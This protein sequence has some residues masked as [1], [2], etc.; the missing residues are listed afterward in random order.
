[1]T[2]AKH[3]LLDELIASGIERRE[4]RWIIEE[5]ALDDSPASIDNARR[6][7]ERRAQGEPLQ[8]VL[9]HWPFR[10][11]DLDVDPRALIP[12]PETEELV[13]LALEQL[14]FRASSAPLMLDLGSGTGAIG[15]SL[16]FELR[17][18]GLPATLVCVDASSDALD[19]ARANARKHELTAV[20]F[21]QSNWFDDLDATFRG[22][23][24]LIAANPPYVSEAEMATLDPVLG[25]EPRIALVARD[26]VGVGGY[27]DI[28]HIIRVAPSWLAPSGVLVLEHGEHQRDAVK[29]TCEEAGFSTLN[30][31]DDVSGRPRMLVARR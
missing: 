20:S 6:A 10:D 31:F 26:A 5:F 2:G 18:R 15:L 16:L 7:G 19:L 13:G 27:A 8:Y 1:V 4:A 22:A 12:R 17:E 24:D 28:E 25:Y 14:A 21:V 23:F 30:L 9:G 11:L 29:A 3:Q